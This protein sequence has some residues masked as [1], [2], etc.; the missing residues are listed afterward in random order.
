MSELGFKVSIARQLEAGE[1]TAEIERA[2]RALLTAHGLPDSTTLVAFP[3]F[4]APGSHPSSLPRVTQHCMTTYQTEESRRAFM[5]SFSKM[6]VKKN[7]RMRVYA[8]TLVDDDDSYDL[9]GTLA[10][11]RDARIRL[12]HHRCFSCF[13]FGSSC[14]ELDR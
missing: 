5:C 9:G 4:L 7:G 11:S 13:K 3:D 8:C 2:Y 14:S 1:N 12:H 6:V 10:A